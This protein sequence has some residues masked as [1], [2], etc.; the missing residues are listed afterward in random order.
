VQE[1]FD[2]RPLTDLLTQEGLDEDLQH[3]FIHGVLLYP[4][5]S[6]VSAKDALKRLEL[7]A[8]SVGR[9]GPDAGP[10]LVPMYGCGE[11]SQAFCRAAAVS[12]AVQV[13]RCGLR[14]LLFDELTNACTGIELENGQRVQCSHLA[15]GLNGACR[16]QE[17][18]FQLQQATVMK[19]IVHRCVA[20]LDAPLLSEQ[21]HALVAVP[22]TEGPGRGH[23]VWGLQL[24]SSTAV[25]PA[26][27]WLLHLWT[28]NSG[29]MGCDAEDK[30][31]S[32]MDAES[33]LLPTLMKLVDCSCLSGGG[34]AS[35]V[36]K[37]VPMS[38]KKP[39]VQS[40]NAVALLAAF[41][42]V[43]AEKINVQG[44]SPGRGSWPPNVM[45]CPG[46]AGA[47][48]MAD[49]V[50]TAKNCYWALFPPQCD[51]EKSKGE[52]GAD[53]MLENFPLEPAS[54]TGTAGGGAGGEGYD[55]DDETVMALQAALQT[56][57]E[58][59]YNKE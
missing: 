38:V 7:Y 21:Q 11:L 48:A 26:G 25:S 42:S 4:T 45:L 20:I 41:F 18:G 5:F 8:E 53:A 1:S 47:V 28:E 54:T 24:G 44:Q 16:I 10:F 55:S 59:E 22:S 6:G 23:V 35:H 46:P 9:Y 37:C 17:E 43:N 2:E 40:N 19:R 31:S 29:D 34:D 51:N 13:L 3:R 32:G 58:K 12:G 36:E 14:G 27:K 57:H 39:G 50:D 30:I 56:P 33:L 52:S 49:V 15:T